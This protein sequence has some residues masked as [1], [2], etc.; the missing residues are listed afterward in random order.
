MPDASSTERVHK[1]LTEDL[2]VRS[3]SVIATAVVEEPPR[4]AEVTGGDV[5]VGVA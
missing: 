5:D 2:T 1:F 3:A 4:D